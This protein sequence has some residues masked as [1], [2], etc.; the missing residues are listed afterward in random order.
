MSEIRKQ[1]LFICSAIVG[2]YHLTDKLIQILNYD[3]AFGLPTNDF[4]LVTNDLLLGSRPWPTPN[5]FPM[6][7]LIIGA[8][9]WLFFLIG[10]IWAIIKRSITSYKFLLIYCIVYCSYLLLTVIY[11]VTE[12]G[13]EE[14]AHYFNLLLYSRLGILFIF[15]ML[16]Y[17]YLALIKAK[18]N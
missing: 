11:I 6:S 3:R 10:A 14:D 4:A 1:T 5:G 7:Y 17:N 2:G 15:F 8:L 18:V 16:L 13:M 9:C 12:V